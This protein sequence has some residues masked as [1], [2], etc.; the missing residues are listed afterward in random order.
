MSEDKKNVEAEKAEKAAEAEAIETRILVRSG[1]ATLA[2]LILSALSIG[3]GRAV[4]SPWLIE[5]GA[6]F[7]HRALL[8]VSRALN[9][10]F[11]SMS[12]ED[13]S[14]LRQMV[15]ARVNDLYF[16]ANRLRHGNQKNFS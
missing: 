9:T 11:F 13:F 7:Y 4:R 15:D 5:V 8:D 2:D 12:Q 14:R 16:A 10:R 1:A 3:L 6:D